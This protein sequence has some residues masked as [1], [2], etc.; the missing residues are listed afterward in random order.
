MKKLA[1][2]LAFL[3]LVFVSPTFASANPVQPNACTNCGPAAPFCSVR[4][5][6]STATAYCSGSTFTYRVTTNCTDYQRGGTAGP[7]YGNRVGQTGTSSYT[8][9][10]G[11]TATG[12]GLATP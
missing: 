3:F 7:F 11:R 4:T 8:C 9:S 2:L 6:G 10:G 5:S 12:A 1:A